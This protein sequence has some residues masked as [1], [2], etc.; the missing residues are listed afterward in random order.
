MR[1]LPFA[2]KAG[3]EA[4]VAT[5]L[6]ERGIQTKEDL[7]EPKLEKLHDPLFAP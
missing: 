7:D 3:L 6:Y 5:L 2:K 1:P 4:S